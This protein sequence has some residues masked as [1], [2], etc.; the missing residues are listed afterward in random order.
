MPVSVTSGITNG[1]G[2]AVKESTMGGIVELDDCK[3]ESR[4]AVKIK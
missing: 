1:V 3:V 4:Q 2:V